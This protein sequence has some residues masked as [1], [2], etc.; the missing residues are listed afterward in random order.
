M[1]N[2]KIIKLSLIEYFYNENNLGFIISDD[3]KNLPVK[4]IMVYCMN[5]IDED[6]L[7]NSTTTLIYKLIEDK[8]YI[9][10]E[11]NINYKN[12]SYNIKTFINRPFDKNPLREIYKSDF[13]L[14]DFNMAISEC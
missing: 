8:L 14:E 1:I 3:C 10:R 4:K 13:S 11:C 5:I 12:Q 9:L 7:L 2:K 6:K